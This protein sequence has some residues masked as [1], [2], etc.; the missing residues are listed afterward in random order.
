MRKFGVLLLGAYALLA[1]SGAQASEASE[2]CEQLWRVAKSA[3]QEADKGA[4]EDD[5]LARLREGFKGTSLD[6]DQRHMIRTT[7]KGAFMRD[8]DQ[9]PSRYAGRVQ[10]ACMN[11]AR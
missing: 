2:F 10:S 11:A 4:D 1:A 5:M 6:S 3:A 9:S 8:K 7:V